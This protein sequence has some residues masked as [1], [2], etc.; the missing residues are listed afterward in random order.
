[1]DKDNILIEDTYVQWKL[2]HNTNFTKYKTREEIAMV[3]RF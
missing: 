1:M 3:R 2:L